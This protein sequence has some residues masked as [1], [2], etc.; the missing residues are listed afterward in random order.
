V[1]EPVRPRLPGLLATGRGAVFRALHPRLAGLSGL[2]P[3]SM[4]LV[5]M[6][7]GGKGGDGEPAAPPPAPDLRGVR[8]MLLP[9]QV[10]GPAALDPELA[11]WLGDR[12]PSTDWV[13]PAELQAAADRAPAWRLR[14]NTI[15]RLTRDVGGGQRVLVDPL[16]GALRQLGAMV[17]SD[18]AVVPM[19]TTE[20]TDSLGLEL[21]VVM[22]VVDIRGGRVLWLHT[23]R[24]RGNP[25]RESAV[26][27]VA[28][29]VA[30]SLVP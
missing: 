20:R 19:A 1:V 25:D 12:A 21:A 16:Y 7:C 2:A 15:Q 6:A 23:V 9:V 10:P 14:L 30:R 26:A 13:L 22:A 3:L 5:A 17:D 18:Y 29:Q 24:S 11:F 4:V 28:E 8:V 27:S